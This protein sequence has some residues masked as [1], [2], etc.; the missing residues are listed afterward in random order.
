M[1]SDRTEKLTKEARKSLRNLV[2]QEL[3]DLPHKI[4]FEER[5]HYRGGFGCEKTVRVHIMENELINRYK[6]PRY[7]KLRKIA[8]AWA[9]ENGINVGYSSFDDYLNFNVVYIGAVADKQYTYEEIRG[10][11]DQYNQEN[12]LQIIRPEMKKSFAAR[13]TFAIGIILDDGKTMRVKEID[14][15]A[16]YCKIISVLIQEGASIKEALLSD[17]LPTYAIMDFTIC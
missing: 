15:N 11:I 7:D 13:A 4:I 6:D 9:V 8:E 17:R 14:G 2:R 16:A 10:L 12:G 3:P 5:R 1:S